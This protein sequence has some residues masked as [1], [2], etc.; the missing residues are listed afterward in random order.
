M[1]MYFCCR[2]CGRDELPGVG[3][4][5][6]P[7]HLAADLQAKEIELRWLGEAL[8]REQRCTHLLPWSNQDR[9]LDLEQWIEDKKK[10]IGLL[11]RYID[12]AKKN[13]QTA[14]V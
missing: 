10:A 13:S 1:S 6:D 3:A 4:C 9:I 2:M 8:A 5:G 7:E 12:E 11:R 14:K